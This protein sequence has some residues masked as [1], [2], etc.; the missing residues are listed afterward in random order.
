MSETE[1]GKRRTVPGHGRRV[2]QIQKGPRQK[3]L[4]S[5]ATAVTAIFGV[6]L[7]LIILQA[8]GLLDVLLSSFQASAAGTSTSSSLGLRPTITAFETAKTAP[9]LG[10]ACADL[11]LRSII[12]MTHQASLVVGLGAAVFLDLFIARHLVK[13]QIN[14]QSLE[15][16]TFGSK[17]VAYGLALIWLTAFAILAY[18]Y[19]VDPKLLSNPKIWGKLVIVIALTV[20]GAFIHTVTLPFIKQCSG[21]CLLDV[22]FKKIATVFLMPVSVSIVSW[23]AAFVLGAFKELNHA[24]SSE[25]IVLLYVAALAVTYVVALG[26][27]SL[28][29]RFRDQN[30]THPVSV[31]SGR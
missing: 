19:F 30:G 16:I 15:L 24:I 5:L 1:F 17:V 3:L 21:Q 25:A 31:M 10:F 13:R 22:P 9:L 28:L 23:S 11:P 20:N 4:A 27:F 12:V 29:I 8:T 26:I 7:G 18:Y 6:I 14:Q 2:A